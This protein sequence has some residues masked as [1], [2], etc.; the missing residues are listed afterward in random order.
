MTDE[1][2]DGRTAARILNDPVFQRAV[3]E[4]DDEI[5]AEWRR[6]DGA[7][8]RERAHADQA[9]L[10]RVVRQLEVIVGRGEFAEARGAD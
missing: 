8:E 3:Q 7:I 6:A 10:R 5:V 4:A 2:R 1:I 9:A